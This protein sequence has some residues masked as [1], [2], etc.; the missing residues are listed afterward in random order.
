MHCRNREHSQAVTAV[1]LYVNCVR[2]T[3]QFTHSLHHCGST[4]LR[5]FNLFQNNSIHLLDVLYF[6]FIPFCIYIFLINGRFIDFYAD[7]GLLKW[8]LFIRELNQMYYY[9]IFFNQVER[10]TPLN[11]SSFINP[12][13]LCGHSIC[14]MTPS[15]TPDAPFRATDNE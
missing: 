5:L 7:L 10:N 2:V 4:K 11:T 9:F 6:F 15:L 13:F 1:A 14:K 12:C 8:K 3:C